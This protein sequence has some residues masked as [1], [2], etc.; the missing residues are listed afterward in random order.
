MS[1][2]YKTLEKKSRQTAF[3]VT[4]QEDV[5]VEAQTAEAAPESV[6]PEAAM[7]SPHLSSAQV[8]NL[9][10][11]HGNQAVMRMLAGR[12]GIGL[13]PAGNDHAIQRKIIKWNNPVLAASGVKTPAE[14]KELGEDAAN[15]LNVVVE[16]AGNDV[17]NVIDSFGKGQSTATDVANAFAGQATEGH[18]RNFVNKLIDWKTNGKPRGVKQSAGYIIEGHADV[19]ANSLGFERQYRKGGSIPDYRVR[20][21]HKYDFKGT[22]KRANTLLDSTS[23]K[24]AMKGH[25]VGKVNNLG[26]RAAVRHP[27]LYDIY[28]DNLGIDEADD[29][30][31]VLD[32][33]DPLVQQ[34]IRMVTKRAKAQARA[35][36]NRKGSL[37]KRKV[38]S[39]NETAKRPKKLITK[40]R[41]GR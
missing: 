20:S 38:V 32:L 5:E 34:R 2:R 11:T 8:L 10:H 30:S 18:I 13:P 4:P 39:Y 7:T 25:I 3:K 15:K 24:E 28:Y 41:R 6:S 33:T 22:P 40:N 17:K 27:H 29:P 37:R 1:S 14:G 9:Q 26:E 23:E 21:K 31:L 16:K 35:T 12:K 36:K 19:L